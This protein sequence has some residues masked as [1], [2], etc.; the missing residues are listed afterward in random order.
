[1]TLSKFDNKVLKAQNNSFKN[2]KATLGR[3]NVWSEEKMVSCDVICGADVKKVEWAFPHSHCVY[4]M[5]E[6][7]FTK[8]VPSDQPNWFFVLSHIKIYIHKM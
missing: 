7:F 8:A 2:T 5:S 3:K 1:M 4:A 6:Q